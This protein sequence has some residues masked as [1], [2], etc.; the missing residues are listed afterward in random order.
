[1]IV[2]DRRVSLAEATKELCEEL[3]PV[4]VSERS[5]ALHPRGSRAEVHAEPHHDVLEPPVSDPRLGQDPAHLSIADEE[6]VGPLAPH[7]HAERGTPSPCSSRP[8][9]SGQYPATRC[10]T[11]RSWSRT[12]ARSPSASSERAVNSGSPSSRCTP[13]PTETPCTSSS[14]TRRTG[15][16]PPPRASPTSTSPRSWTR[17]AK[18]GRR[19]S[20]P[21]TASSPRTGRSR[22]RWRTP[23]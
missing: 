23:A 15:S 12:A 4:D 11:Q 21:A 1:P 3:D 13:T 14:P 19:S 7:V 20:T 22:A 6:V 16:V 5:R 10:P 17:V 9:T 8:T 18:R 2:S